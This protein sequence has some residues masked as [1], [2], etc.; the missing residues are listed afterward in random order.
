MRQ[1][2]REKL[3]R[4]NSEWKVFH[5]EMMCAGYI[6]NPAGSDDSITAFASSFA[7]W[8]IRHS[9]WKVEPPTEKL[10]LVEG[11]QER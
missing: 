6:C 7:Y 1:A 9:G 8:L 11:A 5:A 2:D 3:D 10:A 4:L